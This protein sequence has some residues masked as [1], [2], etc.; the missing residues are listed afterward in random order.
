[1]KCQ[2]CQKQAILHIT[3]IL[4]DDRYEE[5][6]LCDDCAHKYLETPSSPKASSLQAGLLEDREETSQ[7]DQKQC[8]ICHIKF[9][10]FRNTG[11]LGCP[12]DYEVFH[13]ELVPLLDSIHGHNRHVGKIPRRLPQTR[14][15]ERELTELRKQLQE[16][17]VEENY[18]QAAQL[19]DRIR[20]LEQA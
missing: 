18:E 20:T 1:M 9:S 12:H 19:R 11:R 7:L 10:D 5:L 3:E 17:V 16:A 13:A 15:V 2:N 4:S 6:H 8:E 14:Q